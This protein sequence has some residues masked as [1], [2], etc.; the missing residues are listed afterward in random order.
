MRYRLTAETFPAH[1]CD[2]E[3]G[4]WKID[5]FQKYISGN[6]T[7]VWTDFFDSL[8]K[9]CNPLSRQSSDDYIIYSISA[10]NKPLIHLMA[11]DPVLRPLIIRAENFIILV[12]KDKKTKFEQRL[13]SL[14]Y[15]L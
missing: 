2:K 15:L 8:L 7:Q 13:K 1:R 11:N 10:D 6:L 9:R 4:Q 14:G 12:P 3:G 5:F